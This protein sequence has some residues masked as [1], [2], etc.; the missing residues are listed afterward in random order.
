MNENQIKTKILVLKSI[1]I[2]LIFSLIAAVIY[3]VFYA[4]D[5]V[6][7]MFACLAGL[8]LVGTVGRMITNKIAILH[9][10][11]EMLIRD[12][13]KEQQRTLMSTRHTTR[14]TSTKDSGG[15]ITNPVKKK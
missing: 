3:S 13:R 7:M 11:L 2:I 15:T 6:F 9:V 14:R 12:K 1:D 5:K 8:F 4:E 10:Q